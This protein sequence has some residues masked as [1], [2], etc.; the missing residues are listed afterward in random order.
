MITQNG[1]GLHLRAG[2]SLKRIYQI[3]GNIDFA[4]CAGECGAPIWPLP[5]DLVGRRERDYRLTAEDALHLRCPSCAGWARPHV[6]WFDEYYDE[7][8]FRYESSIRAVEAVDVFLV[9]GTAGA[10]SLPRL[11]GDIAVDEEVM[12]I[13]INV[14]ENP[15]DQL[16]RENDGLVLRGSSSELFPEIARRLGAKG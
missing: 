8:R 14:D 9:A 10:T 15:F 11:S 13:D 6:L 2:N 4:R 12:I 1:D 5:M 3:H 7:E 16:A